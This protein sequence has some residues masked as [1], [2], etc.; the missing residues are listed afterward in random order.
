MADRFVLDAGLIAFA[1]VGCHRDADGV[2]EAAVQQAEVFDADRRLNLPGQ[3][4]DRLADVAIVVD[5]LRNGESLE[6][7]VVTVEEGAPADLRTG[8]ESQA[9]RL[10]ELIQEQGHPVIDFRAGRRRDRSRRH[11][12]PAAPDDLLAV[13]GNELMQHVAS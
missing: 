7:E 2:V 5:N 12:G 8:G 13:Q 3:L 11:F 4:G 1:R 9:Q 10:G 6:P